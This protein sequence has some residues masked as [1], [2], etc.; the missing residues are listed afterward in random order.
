MLRRSYILWGV[1]LVP[2][3][4]QL[5]RRALIPNCRDLIQVRLQKCV[6][7]SRGLILVHVP[8]FVRNES[9]ENMA[10]PNVD[11]MAERNAAGAWSDET[12][13]TCD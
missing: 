2:S 7:R 8:Q 12:R 11:T 3:G 1:A 10:V 13:L 9:I 5:E 6:D 4:I